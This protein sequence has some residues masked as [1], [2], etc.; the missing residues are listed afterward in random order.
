[1]R[2]LLKVM[3]KNLK[4]HTNFDEI[5]LNELTNFGIGAKL[6][7]IETGKLFCTSSIPTDKV[8]KLIHMII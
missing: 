8:E 3:R 2:K 4:S 5:L 7:K 6:K 1:M